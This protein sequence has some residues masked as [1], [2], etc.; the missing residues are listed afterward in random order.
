M[1]FVTIYDKDGQAYQKESVD[2]RE[3]LAVGEYFSQPPVVDKADEVVEE[4]PVVDKVT[5]G[6]KKTD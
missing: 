5:K 3:C 4:A 6:P 2:A 1:A